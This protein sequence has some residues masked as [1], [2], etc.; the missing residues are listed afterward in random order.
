MIRSGN[1]G[2]LG[3]SIGGAVIDH[4]HPHRLHTLDPARQFAH[5]AGKSVGFIVAGYLNDQ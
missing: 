3:G 4:H 1:T 5:D 2:R